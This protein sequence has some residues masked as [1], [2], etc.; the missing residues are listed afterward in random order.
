MNRNQIMQQ[1]DAWRKYIADGGGGSWPRDAF[2]ALL[3]DFDE[4]LKASQPDNARNG[5]KECV[6]CGAAIPIKETQ[7]G[8]CGATYP[9]P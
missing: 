7:C 3:D 5:R 1:W 4:Q 9:R 8:N 2:E 6:S